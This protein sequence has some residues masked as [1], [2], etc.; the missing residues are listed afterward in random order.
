MKEPAK[1]KQSGGSPSPMFMPILNFGPGFVVDY[2]KN[3][4][5]DS[6]VQVLETIGDPVVLA[7]FKQIA[8]RLELTY[9]A[10][11]KMENV[12]DEFMKH[13]RIQ[14]LSTSSLLRALHEQG[15]LMHSGSTHPLLETESEE[16][17][18]SQEAEE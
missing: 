8:D 10:A 9:L 4:N 17:E 11:M 2:I 1:L 18:Q 12:S 7:M 5:I 6:R 15:R 16:G 14:A 3:L 13:L